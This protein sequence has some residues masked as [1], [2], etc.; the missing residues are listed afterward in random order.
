MEIK[1]VDVSSPAPS[2]VCSA[3]VGERMLAAGLACLALG[4]GLFSFP[5]IGLLGILFFGA[6]LALL[7]SAG[8]LIRNENRVF[9]LTAGGLVAFLVGLAVLC[10]ATGAITAGAQER[11]LHAEV[12][13]QPELGPVPMPANPPWAALAAEAVAGAAV[14]T[15]GLR[16]RAGWSAVRTLAWGLAALAVVPAA[17]MLFLQLATLLPLGA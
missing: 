2:C 6:A 4:I 16:L 1:S 11:V 7:V 5:I 8:I 10:H 12:M 13:R 3:P 15:V 14:M 17:V 9:V